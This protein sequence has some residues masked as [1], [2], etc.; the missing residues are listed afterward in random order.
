MVI[1]LLCIGDVVGKPGRSVLAQALPGLVE[2]H[3]VHCVICNA[4]NIAGGSGLT[5]QLFEKIRR[6]GVDLVTLGDHIY[7]RQEVIPLLEKSDRI[8][9]PAQQRQDG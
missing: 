9:K 8:V 1:N 2:R 7:R 5:P 4:E 6:Y 3:D